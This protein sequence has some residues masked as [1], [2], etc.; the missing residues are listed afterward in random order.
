MKTRIFF[1]II[2]LLF[3][4]A[5]ALLVVGDSGSDSI[6]TN[7]TGAG[8]GWNY[9]GY[10]VGGSPS[11]M[12]YV[13][14][15]WFVTAN[16]VWS[17]EVVSTKHQETVNLGGTDYTINLSSYTSITNAD[18]TG[19]DL[20]MFRVNE[21]AGLPTGMAVSESLP[22]LSDFLMLIGNGY[23]NSYSTG[24]TWGDGSIYGQGRTSTTTTNLGFGAT[25]YYFSIYDTNVTGSACGQTYDSGGG[26]FVNEQLAGIIGANGTGIGD[27]ITLITDFSVYG[28]QINQASVIPEPTP[29]FL[30]A[31]VALA[32]GVIKRFRYMYQ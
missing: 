15:G 18:G 31:G 19:A 4:S 28:K 8:T 6:Y 12:T 1:P 3:P 2:F 25:T 11:S 26:A 20:C 9:V 24:M 29:A 32:F 13:S 30:F 17:N 7:G 21:F 27:G 10:S 16:H 22:R 23:D 14:N 5:K